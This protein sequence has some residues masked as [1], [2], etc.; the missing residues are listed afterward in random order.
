MLGLA[1]ALVMFAFVGGVAYYQR[2]K[3]RTFVNDAAASPHAKVL[4][5]GSF[6]TR[7]EVQLTRRETSVSLRPAG[8]GKNNPTRWD[9]RVD[10]VRLGRRTSL[11]LGKEGMLSA[12]AKLVHIEDVQLGQPALDDKY[13]IKGSDPDVIRGA[14]Q[15]RPVVDAVHDMFDHHHVF[16][17]QLGPDGAL[18]VSVS[19]RRLAFTEAQAVAWRVL[20]LARALDEAAAQDAVPEPRAPGAKNLP[21]S[22]PASGT[23]VGFGFRD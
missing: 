2:H 5:P 20:S 22:G 21:A 4:Q 19:R 1:Y 8:G 3:Q 6:F 16:Q 9:M 11:K 12:L 10:G 13:L 14:F 17:C 18:H 23:P 7:P 15:H